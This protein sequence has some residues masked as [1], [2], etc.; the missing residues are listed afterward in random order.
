MPA[1][2]PAQ[3]LL[4]RL[5]PDISALVQALRELVLQVIPGVSEQV[6]M[7]WGAIR[8]QQGSSMRDA[9]AS[10]VPHRNHVNLQF[11]DGVDLPDPAGRL[12][13][14]GKRMRHSKIRSIADVR[15]PEVRGLLE[16]AARFRNH[17]GSVAGQTVEAS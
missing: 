9:I 15:A 1:T 6:H 8:Y 17:P 5:T 12:E 4:D 3:P 16:A 14:T 10:L 7:G 13:G 11:S 2:D